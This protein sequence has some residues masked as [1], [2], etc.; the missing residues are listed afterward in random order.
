MPLCLAAWSSASIS[1]R[2]ASASSTKIFVSWSL[3]AILA[4]GIICIW[5]SMALT[6]RAITDAFYDPRA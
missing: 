6:R 4:F 3:V 1:S 2:M 5:S